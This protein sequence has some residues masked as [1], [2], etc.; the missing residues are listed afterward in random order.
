MLKDIKDY[1]LI[2]KMI[3]SNF[4]LFYSIYLGLSLLDSRDWFFPNSR[5]DEID[6]TKRRLFILLIMFP[7]C[8][9]CNPIIKIVAIIIG[10]NNIVK[11]Y[12]IMFCQGY[13]IIINGYY[14]NF[15]YNNLI[16]PIPYYCINSVL[17]EKKKLLGYEPIY[18][19]LG[20]KYLSNEEILTLV[21]KQYAT[22]SNN[23]QI[24]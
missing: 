20:T 19:Y 12:R 23:L 24:E 3:L 9:L 5:L 6:I 13:R 8:L 18:I 10:I 15:Y 16:E 21:N 17:K 11:Y 14:N 4:E 1:Q 7:L 2:I 22:S